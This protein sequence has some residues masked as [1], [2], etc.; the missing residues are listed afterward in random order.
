MQ[1]GRKNRCKI[2]VIKKKKRK[3]LDLL[4]VLNL[5]DKNLIK[6]INCQI[7]PV[8]DYVINVC[9]LGKGDLEKLN[10]TVKSVLRREV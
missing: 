6:A 8:A 9:N 2:D 3:T 7:I 5:N 10:M 1:R 4:T